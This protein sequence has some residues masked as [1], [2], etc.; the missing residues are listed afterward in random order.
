M[1]NLTLFLLAVNILLFLFH[2]YLR[3]YFYGISFRA[4]LQQTAQ[5]IVQFWLDLLSGKPP[6]WM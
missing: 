4:A 6:R 3:W 2:A 1:S 5:S